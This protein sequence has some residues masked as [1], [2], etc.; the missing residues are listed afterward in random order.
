MIVLK[1]T[2]NRIGT[3]FL[4]MLIILMSCT[5][6][7]AVNT[8]PESNR[9]NVVLVAD[10]SLS[11]VY[12]DPEKLRADSIDL[13]VS[14]L[15]NGGNMVGSVVF[16]SDIVRK[17]DIAEIHG[18]TEKTIITGNVRE[19]KPGGDTN[20][21]KALLSAIEMLDKSKNEN[22][23]SIIILLT[24]GNTDMSSE[25]LTQKALDDKETALEQAR[26]AGYRI[27]TICLNKDNTAKPDEMKQIAA[28]TGGE[29]REVTD[30][31]NL[32]EVFDL[33]Y[34]IIF[35]TK[36]TGL[37][38]AKVPENGIL[39]FDFDVANIGVE[40]VNIIV[41]GKPDSY[42]LTDS[43]GK[44]YSDEQIGELRY[45]SDRFDL[46]KIVSPIGGRWKLDIHAKPNTSIKVFKIYNPNLSIKTSI[47]PNEKDYKLGDTV[48]FSS[49]FFEGNN[50]VS[51]I[52]KFKSVSAILEVSDY[53]GKIISSSKADL[54]GSSFENIFVP[55]EYGTY[56]AVVKATNGE[57]DVEGNKFII[58]VGNTAPVVVS[59]PI[60]KHVNRWPFLI[61]TDSTINLSSAAVDAEDKTL[62]FEIL[63]S[64]WMPED[65]TLSGDKL[66]IDNFSVSKGS[67]KVKAV[68]SQGAFCEFDVKITSTNVGL[69]AVILIIIAFVT[70]LTAILIKLYIELGRPFMGSFSIRN[71]NSYDNI[72]AQKSRGRMR[73]ATF[74]V[75]QTGLDR[76]SYFQATGKTYVYFKSKK[77][78]FTDNSLGKKK[79]IRIDSGIDVKISPTQ[80]MENGIV[81]RFESLLN[82]QMF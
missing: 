38:D 26:D 6:A 11:M 78:F 66:T 73:L 19:G 13:F 32:Q 7:F 55:S 10:E 53:S 35:S 77:A 57:I 3:I 18:K 44:A 9:F 39:S 79:K 68:D 69:W 27:F 29:F 17:N 30:A 41:F 8:T 60:K 51:D 63:S 40:E 82:N 70:V 72:T 21:G 14:L 58:N 22:L 71:I 59:S 1:K 24:D 62:K 42:N 31:S 4:S 37:V 80:D 49:A 75:G 47:E 28:A 48:F 15:A 67:F 64:S 61:K 16:N 25:E 5:T 45:P 50:A 43:A 2:A 56:Y 23:P 65:Y 36:S 34:Q 46:L 54:S 33:F 81:V 12:T 74:S 20:I 76:N 52:S